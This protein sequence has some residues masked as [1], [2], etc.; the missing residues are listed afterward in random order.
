M[1]LTVNRKRTFVGGNRRVHVANVT[2]ST[3]SE[4][5]Q[6]TSMH[7]VEGYSLDPTTNISGGASLSGNTLTIVSSAGGTFS[8]IAYG[9]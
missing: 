5:Y 8:V 2:A 9:Q 6:I 1:S 4:T 3:N 7:I